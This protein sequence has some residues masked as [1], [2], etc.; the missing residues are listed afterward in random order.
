MAKQRS[1]PRMTKKHLA[2]AQREQIQ[3]R[4]ILIGTIVT[5]VLALGFIAYGIYDTRFSPV[6]VVNGVAISATEFRSRVRLDE[7]ITVSQQSSADS[8]LSA[9]ENRQTTADNILSDLIDEELIRQELVRRGVIVSEEDVDRAIGESFGY[10]PEGTPTP[11]PTYT[12][13][14][15]TLAPTS[16]P[17][18]ATE[19]PSPTPSPTFTPGPSPTAT[20]TRTPYPTPTLVTKE[21]YQIAFQET[22]D[23]FTQINGVKEGDVRAWFR[24]AT[25]REKLRELFQAEIPKE[26]EFVHARHILVADEATAQE[27]LRLLGEGQTWEDLALEFSTDESNKAEGGDLGWF[28]RGQM[29]EAFE[30]AAFNAQI[31]EVVGPIETS[32]GWHLIQVL[33]KENR[34]LSYYELYSLSTNAFDE[35]LAQARASAVI[36]QETDL[37]GKMPPMPDLTKLFGGQ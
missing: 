37:L 14:P 7:A 2:R 4:W 19:G 3:R 11:L 33:G 1:T 18:T 16:I 21:G 35:W 10:F 23:R 27:V 30:T 31:G 5:V 20:P 24:G 32:L 26:Q 36:E 28:R 25:N 12:P 22:V 15:T 8:A 6:A 29:V 17:P 13:A 9:L 34:E